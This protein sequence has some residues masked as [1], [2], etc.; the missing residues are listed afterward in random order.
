MRRPLL[1]CVRKTALA[2]LRAASKRA[3]ARTHHVHY[4][5]HDKRRRMR[6]RALDERARGVARVRRASRIEWRPQRIIQ[7]PRQ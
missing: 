1:L 5:T 6:R 3:L 2:D 7:C 4:Q